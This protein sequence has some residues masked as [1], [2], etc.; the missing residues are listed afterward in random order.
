MENVLTLGIEISSWGEIDGTGKPTP[1]ELRLQPSHFY[2]S[3]SVGA[4]GTGL[5]GAVA[6]RFPA[7]VLVEVLRGSCCHRTLSAAVHYVLEQ[8]PSTE[9]M[10][11]GSVPSGDISSQCLLES[12]LLP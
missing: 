8:F 11:G 7:L 2:S 4:V 12:S 6:F 1:L 10:S 3:E 5:L 9:A